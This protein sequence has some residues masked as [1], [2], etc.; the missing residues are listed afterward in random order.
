MYEPSALQG[1]SNGHGLGLGGRDC[2]QGQ[3]SELRL[4]PTYSGKKPSGLDSQPKT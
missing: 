2:L 4:L 1:T 3:G